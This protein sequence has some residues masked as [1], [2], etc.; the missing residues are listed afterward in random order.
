M[1][2]MKVIFKSQRLRISVLL[3]VVLLLLLGCE[4]CSQVE[5]GGAKWY[6]LGDIKTDG[7]YV[8]NIKGGATIT[9]D[10]NTGLQSYTIDAN[11]VYTLF[12][13][14]S[15]ESKGT[16]DI[17]TLAAAVAEAIIAAANAGM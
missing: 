9:V 2:A 12:R 14:D 8:E 4:G 16:L 3:S 15:T 17:D 1:E 7:A 10:P 13:F 11:G 5:Y 6:R